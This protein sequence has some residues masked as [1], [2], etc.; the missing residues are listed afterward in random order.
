MNARGE[1]SPRGFGR[2]R[3]SAGAQLAATPDL[4]LSGHVHNYQRFSAPES[5]KQLIYI[6]AGAG[7]RRGE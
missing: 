5:N 3:R 7:S 6:V 1:L 2:A 4:V